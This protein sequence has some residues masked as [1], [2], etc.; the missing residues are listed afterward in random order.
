MIKYF[1]GFN[2]LRFIAAFIVILSHSILSISKQNIKLNLFFYENKIFH[3]GA[4]AVNFFF[5]LSGF[6]ITYLL[7]NEFTLN[8]KINIK[9]FY[10]RRVLRIWPLYFLIIFIGF[11]LLEVVY[12][13]LNNGNRYFEFSNP[14]SVLL[15]FILFLP[16]LATKIYKMGLL[17]PLWSIGVEEQF[18]L[19][20]AP[21]INFI[22][23]RIFISATIVLILS[24]IIY[25][26][27]NSNLC[28]I[29]F[30]N[31]L[32]TLRFHYMAIG[33]IFALGIKEKNLYESF[34][35]KKFFRIITPIVLIFYLN[36]KIQI[37]NPFFTDVVVAIF[38]SILLINISSSKKTWVNL[39]SKKISYLGVISYGIYMYHLS[40]DYMLR[41]LNLKFHFDKFFFNPTVYFIFYTLIL[42]LI[43][44]II[45]H[46]SYQY[47]EL[48]F[49]KKKNKYS[50]QS[51]NLNNN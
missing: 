31:F 49:I 47:F 18:Y 27:S 24:Y 4:E 50:F 10:W 35:N 9:K 25:L 7:I 39:E 28:S 19:F 42:T 14:Y 3:S 45:S 30:R 41:T 21:L 40:V 17:N 20:W 5:T 37:F 16:N 43:T 22:K 44:I 23:G 8:N 6:L 11:F 33:A 12:P 38:Y 51:D 32:S 1:S 29:E 13:I 26:F 46:Y 36:Y 34:I 15:L 2:G 48:Y